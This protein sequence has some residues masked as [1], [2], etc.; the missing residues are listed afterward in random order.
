[1]AS[2][3]RQ[4]TAAKAAAAPRK[5]KE[6]DVLASSDSEE[7]QDPLKALEKT[8]PPFV[9]P[10]LTIKE[11]LGAIPAHCFERSALR[12]ST[13][14]VGD[15]LM[16]AA[17]G[18][19]AYHIEPA[20]SFEGGKYLVGWAGFA[21][22]WASWLAYWTLQGWVMT[23]IWILGASPLSARRPLPHARL[24]TDVVPPAQATSAVTRRSRPPRPSTTRWVSSSTPSSSSPTTRGASRTPS[25]TP[26]PVT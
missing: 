19:A 13:Y 14:V 9:V 6:H 21:A 11:V 8:Y 23:G 2:T 1:M 4:R 20:F 26:R 12:S 3:V 7:E 5:E 24:D 17:L 18:Y 10:N 15:F 22:K 25:T 16:V